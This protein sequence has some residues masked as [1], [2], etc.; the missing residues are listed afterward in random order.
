MFRASVMFKPCPGMSCNGANHGQLTRA[1]GNM[2]FGRAMMSQDVQLELFTARKAQIGRLEKR[3]GVR[4]LPGPRSC[5]ERRFPL[6][7]PTSLC[8]VL[9]F[10]SV[11]RLRLRRLISSHTTLS[12]TIFLTPSHSHNFVRQHLSHTSRGRRG[13]G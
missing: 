7:F 13:T 9:V 11:S 6:F 10:D 2:G 5:R 3:A 1:K 4:L 8:G 12:H